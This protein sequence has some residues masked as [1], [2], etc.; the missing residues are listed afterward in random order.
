MVNPLN[1]RSVKTGIWQARN[2]IERIH[3]QV[4][5]GAEFNPGKGNAR[6][7]PC[8]NAQGI[9]IPTIYG[10]ENISVAV[11]ETVYHDV[12]TGCNNL[13]FD[14]GK[15]DKLVYSQL[16]PNVDLIIVDINVRLLRKWGLEPKDVLFS[17]AENYSRTQVLA[18]QIYQDNPTAQAI[19]WTSKQHG[20]K[21]IMLFGDRLKTNELTISIESQPLW[22]SNSIIKAVDLLADEMGLIT[23]HNQEMI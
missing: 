14:L 10:G 19:I 3:H 5:K 17:D 4:F 9:P 23:Y 8:K 11:M 1:S 12:P 22:S 13:P 15:L 20:D 7:S 6:F 2:P 16:T 18:S 21:A